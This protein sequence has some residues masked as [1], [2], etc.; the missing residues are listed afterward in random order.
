M[1]V[2]FLLQSLFLS[3]L[4]G[5][6]TTARTNRILKHVLTNELAKGFNFA[7]QKNMKEAFEKLYLKAVI[8]RKFDNIKNLTK[9]N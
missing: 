9:I 3:T 7:G 2:N 5:D 8:V 1:H 4:G 6:T